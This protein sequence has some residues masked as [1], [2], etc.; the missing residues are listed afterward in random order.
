MIL[1]SSEWKAFQEFIGISILW[2]PVSRGIVVEPISLSLQ[3]ATTS[4]TLNETGPTEASGGIAEYSGR[5]LLAK[6]FEM[7][8]FAVLV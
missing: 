2:E 3:K 5:V 7:Y 1:N 8:V 6:V 4:T